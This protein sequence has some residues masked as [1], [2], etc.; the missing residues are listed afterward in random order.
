MKDQIKV[1]LIKN[2]ESYHESRCS[3]LAECG[4]NEDAYSIYHEIVV[5]EKEPED[6]M[7]ILAVN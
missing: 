2:L 4:R 6:Y 7:F 5:D 1:K 3:E